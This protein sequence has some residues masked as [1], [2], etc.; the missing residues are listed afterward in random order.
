MCRKHQHKYLIGDGCYKTKVEGL[1]QMQ[2]ILNWAGYS[3]PDTTESGLVI[4]STKRVTGN[5]KA[6]RT[7]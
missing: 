3:S 1:F 5:D 4:I 2:G 7:D 6:K